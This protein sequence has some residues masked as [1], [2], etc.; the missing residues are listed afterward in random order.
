MTHR[1][2]VTQVGIRH[3]N[4][5]LDVDGVGA[6][7]LLNLYAGKVRIAKNASL[8]D[9]VIIKP[10]TVDGVKIDKMRVD[11]RPAVISAMEAERDRRDDMFATRYPGIFELVSCLNANSL[12]DDRFK[13]MME[14]GDNDGVN[15]PSAPAMTREEARAKYP[16]ANAY[17]T[18]VKYADSDPSSQVG[19]TRRCAGEHAI[20][21]LESGTDVISTCNAMIAESQNPKKGI[22]S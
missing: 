7:E 1:P 19:Y 4:L 12:Y 16:V 10:I 13:D 11:T 18:I 2:Y 14:D 3:D 6:V 20:E 5:I 9:V 21:A 8:V 22:T 17:L 15:P